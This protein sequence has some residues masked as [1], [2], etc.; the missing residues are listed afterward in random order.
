[1]E[2]RLSLQSTSGKHRIDHSLEK[3]AARNLFR[4][5]TLL[6]FSKKAEVSLLPNAHHVTKPF[7]SILRCQ[8]L[9]EKNR[10]TFYEGLLKTGQA[11]VTSYISL[12]KN[13]DVE[14]EVNGWGITKLRSATKA[15]LK[16]LSKDLQKE[17]QVE[18][19]SSDK[20]KLKEIYWRVYN[21]VDDE[22]DPLSF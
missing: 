19:K 22:E 7:N 11:T 9:A 12:F 15:I 13:D 21:L 10:K 5:N 17:F 3:V 2:D 4:S 14:E 8:L 16:Y 6:D 1:M 18:L 20:E